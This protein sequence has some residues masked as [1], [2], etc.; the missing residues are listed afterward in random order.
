MKIG[1]H[2][3]ALVNTSEE[4]SD[5]FYH[6]LLG[7]DKKQSRLVPTE[8]M[9]KIFGID[10][11]A[12]LIYYGNDQ[13]LLFEI[14]VIGFQETVPVSHCCLMV[15]DRTAFLQTGRHLGVAINQIPKPD[16]GSLVFV[17]DWDNNLFEIK[18]QN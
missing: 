12:K 14:F 10:Q 7:L 9:Q 3:I 5:R 16:G 4:K 2:H 13:G 15:A 1:L 8:Q 17:R 6:G 11:Q 18:E